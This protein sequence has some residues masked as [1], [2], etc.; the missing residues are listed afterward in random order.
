MK[1][2]VLQENLLKALASSVRVV[3]NKPQIPVLSHVL[4]RAGKRGLEVQATNLEMGWRGWVGASVSEEGEI[5]V[6]VKTLF[7]LVGN[8]GAGKIELSAEGALLK[9]LS[10]GVKAMVNG[11]VAEEFPILPSFEREE[12]LFFKS[13]VFKQLIE[14]AVFASAADESRPV[15][16]AVMVRINGGKIELVGTDGFRLSQIVASIESSAE[17]KDLLIPA[18]SLSELS[19]V[20]DESVTEIG[21]YVAGDTNQV[22]FKA[23]EVELSTRLVSG[24]FPDYKKILP[25]DGEISAEMSKEDL[26]RA[27]KL[28]AVFARESAN[29]VKVDLRDNQVLVSANAAQVGDNEV[30]VDAKVIGEVSMAFNYRYVLDYLNVVGGSSV[31]L[32]SNGALSAGLWLGEAVKGYEFKHVIMPVRVEE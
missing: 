8:L 3:G 10:S 11:S 2:S 24:N 29:I 21:M 4:L 13:E 26:L 6:P 25:S 28:A 9:I 19:R 22:I 32:M 5:T 27:I 1:V 31:R 15:L 16:T 14:K 30:V 23:G 18:R 20:I 17:V 12:A 7:E